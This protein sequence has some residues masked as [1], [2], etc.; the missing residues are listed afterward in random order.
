MSLPKTLF[1]KCWWKAEGEG[2]SQD[3]TPP[4]FTDAERMGTVLTVSGARENEEAIFE[5]PVFRNGTGEQQRWVDRDAINQRD[6]VIITVTCN[7]LTPYFFERVEATYG[8]YAAQGDVSA[9]TS[10]KTV[11]HRGWFKFEATDDAGIV[12]HASQTWAKLDIES[13]EYPQTGYVNATFTVRVL[14]SAFNQ[15]G[16][17]NF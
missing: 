16:F 2:S 11:T 5:T 14:D 4:P 1:K 9:Y 15:G 17:R 12:I 13:W 6:R 3:V 7:E 10:G 8:P